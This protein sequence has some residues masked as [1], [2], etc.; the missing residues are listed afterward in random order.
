MK[1]NKLF[2][3]RELMNFIEDIIWLVI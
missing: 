1:N 2:M 3:K